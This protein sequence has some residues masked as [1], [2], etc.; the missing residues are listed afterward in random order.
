MIRSAHFTYRFP[1]KKI[2]G[3]LKEIFLFPSAKPREFW[4]ISPFRW[5]SWRAKSWKLMAA[6]LR[7]VKALRQVDLGRPPATTVTGQEEGRM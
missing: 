7:A 6:E 2:L 5:I 3:V 1:M 4:T